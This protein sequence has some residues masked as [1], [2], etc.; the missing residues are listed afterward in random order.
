MVP[1]GEASMTVVCVDHVD[2]FF[3]VSRAARVEVR[4][5]PTAL[6]MRPHMLPI[7]EAILAIIARINDCIPLSVVV[8]HHMRWRRH[9][10]FHIVILTFDVNWIW[11]LHI[12]HLWWFLHRNWH[13]VMDD[14]GLHHSGAGHVDMHIFRW[15]W[16]MVGV[17]D[18]VHDWSMSWHGLWHRDFHLLNFG[19]GVIVVLVHN[20]VGAKLSV[21]V[22]APTCVRL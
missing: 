13:L 21:L 19:H 9:W 12:N 1:V 18:G 15:A 7:T 5:A 16:H 8:R 14:N 11:L 2:V 17:V 4:T 3:P 22:A 6:G 10:H 20:G